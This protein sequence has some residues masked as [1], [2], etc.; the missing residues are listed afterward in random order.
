LS[1]ILFI[2]TE[3]GGLDPSVHALLSIGMAHW[4]D[5]EILGTREILVQP[6]GR[7]VDSRALDINKIDLRAHVK[8]ALARR[9]AAELF[10]RTC[11]EWFP[12]HGKHNR[13]TL[14]GHNVGFDVNFIRPLFGDRWADTYSHAVIDTSSVFALLWHSGRIQSECR[15]LDQGLR[16]FGIEVASGKRHTALGD[17]VAT[18]LVYGAAVKSLVRDQQQDLFSFTDAPVPCD[19]E[20]R[21]NKGTWL[22]AQEAL[23]AVRR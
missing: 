22:A 16:Y 19:L 3:T 13:I 20:P 9:S 4:K 23:A 8:V 1:E 15:S 7:T 10:Y 17:A 6:G 18:A 14:G 2:D 5:G 12:T 21:K 11:E